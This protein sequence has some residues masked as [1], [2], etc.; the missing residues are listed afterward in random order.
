[1]T[2]G[3]DKLFMEHD[4]KPDCWVALGK[5]VD[6]SVLQYPSSSEKW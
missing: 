3:K 4:L 6:L 1:M 2:L 5:L